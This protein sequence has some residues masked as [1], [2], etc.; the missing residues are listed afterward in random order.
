MEKR[1]AYGYTCGATN[2][3]KTMRHPENSPALRPRAERRCSPTDRESR[4]KRL[5]W[6]RIKRC[7]QDFSPGP[8]QAPLPGVKPILPPEHGEISLII[9]I[10]ES[11]TS[12]Q[13]E[14]SLTTGPLTLRYRFYFHFGDEQTVSRYFSRGC[15]GRRRSDR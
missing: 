12:R 1:I 9:V 10:F 8:P 5:V 6:W 7:A 13:M 11:T 2:A 3:H 4:W 14:F 15:H